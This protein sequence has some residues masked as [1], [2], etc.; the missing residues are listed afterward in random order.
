MRKTLLIL[1]LAAGSLLAGEDDYNPEI[2]AASS[3]AEQ[4]IKNFQLPAGLK[5][6]LFAA[7]P[8][9]A[10]PVAISIDQKGRVY[11]AETFRAGVGDIDGP[12]GATLDND[13]PHRTIDERIAW[14][15]QKWGADAA[16]FEKDHE[17]IRL[18]EDTNGGGKAD[19]DTVFM[20]SPGI[21]DGIGAGV[22]ADKGDVYWTC[23]PNLWKLRDSKGT[24]KADVRQSLHYGY[25]VHGGIRGH[26]L[27][28]LRIGPDGKLYMTMGDR[29][30]H[31]VQ[32]GRVISSPDTGGVLRCN[33]DGSDLEIFALGLRNS[34]DLIFD[35][36]GNLFT[37]DND[38]GVGDKCKII[39]LVEGSDNGWRNAY[40]FIHL[41]TPRGMWNLEKLWQKPFAG[42]AAYVIPGITHLTNGPAGI[43]YYPGTGLP[44][45]F[46]KRFFLADFRYSA[47]GSGLHTFR[48]NHKGAGFEFVDHE[49]SIWNILLTDADFG[50]D[51]QL[52]CADWISGGAMPKKGRIYRIF[53]PEL[54][55]SDLVRE[56]KK[57]LNE[58][59]EQ[60][61]PEELI[62]LLAHANTYVRREA[63]FQLASLGKKVIEPLVKRAQDKSHQLARIHAIWA[64]GQIGRTDAT[65]LEPLIPLLA[66]TDAELRAQT[67]KVLGDGRCKA[68]FNALVP[69]LKDEAPR[70][71]F[72]TAIALGKLDN[73]AALE[74]L[75]AM[76]RE[77][78]DADPYL[79]HAAVMGLAG[80][81]KPA[82]LLKHAT[83]ASVSVR[84]GLVVAL[85]RLASPEVATFLKDADPLVV[86][87]AARAIHDVPIPDALPQLA[88]LLDSVPTAA[89]DHPHG[90]D[91][92]ERALLLR[93]MNANF[94]LGG[95]DNAKSLA[96]AAARADFNN[97]LRTEALE[98]LTDWAE[99]RGRD[100][101]LNMWRPLAPRDP[102]PVIAV[103]KPF[104]L[105]L[106]NGPPSDL[107]TTAS[108]FA[109][110]Y[111]LTE[112]AE[113]LQKLTL[114][115]KQSANARV[116]AFNGLAAQNYPKILDVVRAIIGGK[117]SKLRQAALQYLAAANAADAVPILGQT[118]DSSPAA[119]QQTAI[120]LLAKMKRAEADA[121]L[122]KWLD[123]F[124]S[125]PPAIQLDLLEAAQSSPNNDLKS[126]AAQI[127]AKY[128]AGDELAPFKV[129]LT[130]GNYD[131]GRKLFFENEKVQCS[132]CHKINNKGGEVG[133]DLSKVATNHDRNYLLESLIM[134]SAQIAPGFEVNVA[135]LKDGRI[136]IG[137]VRTD[138]DTRLVLVSADGKLTEIKK[139][140]I[141]TR[142]R[143]KE[144]A[145]PP[146][147][148][149]LTKVEI[150]NAI[151]YLSTLK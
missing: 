109:E 149:V 56:T 96:A 87:E 119:E 113:A 45:H 10:N 74:P 133:P 130:G 107:Q 50:P 126:R 89:A 121:L 110:K 127:T 150:R 83:D 20:I 38:S 1:S 8:Q 139:D 76:L 47:S 92:A 79:R 141:K 114:D 26:D 103:A 36:Y 23:S 71:K 134:P 69:L 55:K 22:L 6:E 135:I 108:Q 52:Y 128:P 53:D 93:E 101:V 49:K 13:L 12:T 63:Q 77:N 80:T 138:D 112:A 148:E 24:G 2:F 129:C 5:A 64:L 131:A 60:R 124:D 122:V 123:K 35:E 7:E 3:D 95:A 14:L 31:I 40:Q 39:Y 143:Q 142:R 27:H 78:A 82:D 151:E 25:G 37:C 132:R 111:K 62:R 118:L 21:L 99:P 41:P 65:A 102:A 88:K 32:N 46:N 91:E 68:A 34:E 44:E 145:M 98:A 144:S 33:L 100:R 30:F 67:A 66:D 43:T 75:L 136:V 17:R 106:L 81:Q 137:N 48:L 73:P 120:A 28:A 104:I 146:M 70:P 9:L 125:A 115:E 19:R 105:E 86:I 16:K 140:E 94:R 61:P 11:V 59:M 90:K 54:Q 57:L 85:R 72:F 117:E 42:Q 15:K 29:G 84:L 4:A 97:E 147:G 51:S 18:L 58:G 116:A